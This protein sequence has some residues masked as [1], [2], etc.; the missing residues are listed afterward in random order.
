MNYKERNLSAVRPTQCDKLH[1]PLMPGV[2]AAVA[3]IARDP[4]KNSDNEE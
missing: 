4:G 1:C 3:A 2:V